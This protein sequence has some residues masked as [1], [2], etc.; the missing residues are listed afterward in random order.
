MKQRPTELFLEPL[1]LLADGGL[2]AMDPLTGTGE[3]AGIHH[4]DKTA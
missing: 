4:R 1:D 3:A 2:S